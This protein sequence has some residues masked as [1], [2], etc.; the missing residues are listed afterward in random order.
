MHTEEKPKGKQ[1]ANNQCEHYEI[2]L[3]DDYRFD[4]HQLPSTQLIRGEYWP[5]GN[6]MHFPKNWGKEKGARHMLEYLK[7]DAK[8]ML[9]SANKRMEAI[10]ELERLVNEANWKG[11]D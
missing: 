3:T 5:V 11:I 2:V 6:K 10:D 4:I 7:A 1:I 8:R 9:E